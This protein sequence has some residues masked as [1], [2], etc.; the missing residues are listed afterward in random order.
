MANV[1]SS[2]DSVSGYQGQVQGP[3]RGF[4]GGV[5][6]Q[7]PA[8]FPLQI[9]VGIQGQGAEGMRGAQQQDRAIPWIALCIPWENSSRSLNMVGMHMVSISLSWP[10][11]GGA[12]V[13]G[14]PQHIQVLHPARQVSRL[15][16]GQDF[17]P[18]AGQGLRSALAA[19]CRP[20]GIALGI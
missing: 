8:G 16:P 11:M 13:H 2:R 9:A 4:A 14:I 18:Q 10:S 20:L 19:R 12:E 6:E 7:H 17:V 3:F 1:I 15:A 5:N